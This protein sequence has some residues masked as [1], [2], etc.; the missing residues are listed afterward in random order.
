MEDL[1]LTLLVE[2]LQKAK[3]LQ[4]SSDF[5]S[6]IEKEIERKTIRSMDSLYS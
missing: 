1:P 2:A 6:L 5:I 4:L 3:K